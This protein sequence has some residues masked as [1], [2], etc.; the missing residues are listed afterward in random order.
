[1]LAHLLA[2]LVERNFGIELFGP[3]SKFQPFHFLLW[4]HLTF[5]IFSWVISSKPTSKFAH[6]QW[7]F[8]WVANLPPK[9]DQ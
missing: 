5:T 2:Y 1:M 6:D 7:T 3:H 9:K 4:I 8:S